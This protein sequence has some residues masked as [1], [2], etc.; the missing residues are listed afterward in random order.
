MAEIKLVNVT[1]K[2]EDEKK[3]VE[4]F[5][6]EIGDGE[7]VVL[8]GPTHSGKSPILRMIAGLDDVTEGELFI[9][10]TLSNN[11]MPK[12]RNVAMVFQNQQLMPHLSVY[13]NIAFGLKLRKISPLDINVKIREIARIMDIENVLSR[14]PKSLTSIERQRVIIARALVREPNVVLFDDTLT[15]FDENLTKR[16]RSELVKLQYRLNLTFIFATRD[17]LDA[18]SMATRIVVMN[19]GKIEQTGTPK[20]IYQNPQTAF[21]A[22]YVGSPQINFANVRLISDNGETKISMLGKSVALDESV[23]EKIADIAEYLDTE[24]TLTLGIRP[25]N[26]NVCDKENAILTAIVDGVEDYGAYKVIALKMK[27]KTISDWSVTVSDDNAYQIDQEIG[28]NP[29]MSKIYLFDT[30]TD[31]TV[32]NK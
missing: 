2:Y 17:Q 5:S 22:T 15:S 14:K 6:L 13:D 31:V 4:N 26:V 3:I 12:D 28:L 16:V 19:D 24:K 10:D 1:K 11:L 21:V 23:K 18:M 29:D 27:E 25:E 8:L 20:E 7:F 32:F 30:E 9:D